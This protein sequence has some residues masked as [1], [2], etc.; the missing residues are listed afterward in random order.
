MPSPPPLT[1]TLLGSP[2]VTLGDAVVRGFVSSKAAALLYYLAATGRSHTREAL[3][4]LLWPETSNAQAFKN[5]R[6]VLSN[7]RRLFEPY[8]AITRD[9]AGLAP[10]AAIGVDARR[11]ET[12]LGAQ[13]AAADLE[14]VELYGGDF[15]AGFSVADA[16]EYEEWALLERERLRRLLLDALARLA[17][18]ALAR[19]AYADGVRFT[20]RLLA[21]DP[22]REAAHRQLMLLLARSGQRGAAL[23][24]YETCR[25]VLLDELGIDPD[26][27]TEALHRQILDGAV[28]SRGIAELPA[29]R[30]L[31]ALPQPLTPLLGRDAE[32]EQL[33][34]QLHGSTR[35][36]TVAGLGGV[37][38]TRLALAAGARLVEEAARF[39][40]SVMNG[41]AMAPLATLDPATVDD[42]TSPALA[43]CIADALR[44][45]LGGAA[46]PHMQLL[47]Y[48]SEKELLLVLDSCEHLPAVGPFA[49]A[50]LERAPRLAIIATSRTRLNVLGEQVLELG[51]LALAPPVDDVD[52]AALELF[53]RTALSVNP[54]LEWNPAVRAAAARI[55]ELV[56]GLPLGIELAA[57][58][59]RMLTCPDIAEA[60]ETNL[61]LLQVQQRHLPPRHHSLRAVFD[62]S[63]RLLTPEQQRGLRQLSVFQG[64]FT[65]PASAAVVEHA[66]LALLMAL[67]DHSLVRWTQE[68]AESGGR[69]AVLELVRKYAG[70]H[71]AADDAERAAT[72]KRHSAYYLDLLAQAADAL[73]GPQQQSA[74]ASLRLEVENLR[75]AWRHAVQHGR[76]DDLARA[77]DGLCLF[78]EM[79]SW[80]AE[81]E[82]V[83]ADAAEAARAR[84]GGQEPLVAQLLARQ[85]WFAFHLGHHAEAY[86]LIAHSCIVLEQLGQQRALAFPLNRLAAVC[87]HQGRYGEAHRHAEAALALCAASEDLHGMAVAKTILGQTAFLIGSYDEAR[88]FSL[89]SLT[90]E[91]ELGN[92]WGMV[93]TLICLGRVDQALGCYEE[94]RRSFGEG[95]AIRRALGDA[96]GIAICLNHVGDTWR[97]QGDYTAARECYEES[98]GLFREIGQRAGVATSL[99]RLGENTLAMGEHELAAGFFREALW[100][101][102]EI[103]ALPQVLEALAGAAAALAPLEPVL[104]Q[105]L[106]AAVLAQ[107]AATHETLDRAGTV[108]S[109]GPSSSDGDTAE[110]E[111]L[112][113]LVAV[114]L[115]EEPPHMV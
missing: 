22:T 108:L 4:G 19:G 27:A 73:R 71:L 37:G 52:A 16:P 25:A 7:L 30:P 38:K 77:L 1:I 75:L 88:Q 96:R 84:L 40:R 10:G 101:A 46:P 2:R 81:G 80:F 59:V 20:G 93:F 54:R 5:L 12:L 34:A 105:R 43:A 47:D 53:R 94:A 29:L 35:L 112:E 62:H 98:L 82:E 58:L 109:G 114:L 67:L 14:A 39:G 51:G 107:P 74:L 69:Y 28:P 56:D 49:V 83:F 113:Q 72:L 85:G 18:D 79:R 110:P 95:L 68:G 87:F 65:L 26:E 50:L 44:F 63:W 33:L 78:Y 48:L 64:G 100:V 70:E 32:L 66:S 111:T 89:E 8:L 91:R 61:E 42:W 106:A 60:L 55:C 36:V 31:P 11:F 99:A 3:A 115:G 97:Q 17:D 103:G 41:A 76:A 90:I 9:A 92:Q 6:D 102:W 24:Q 21:F 45:P 57:S 104:A 15:L 86:T 23:A 13:Q